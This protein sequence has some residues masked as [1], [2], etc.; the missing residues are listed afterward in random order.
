[1]Y[2]ILTYKKAPLKTWKLKKKNIYIKLF[3][4]IF[5]AMLHEDTEFIALITWGIQTNTYNRQLHNMLNKI[6]A[7]AI[8]PYYVSLGQHV[9]F[10]PIL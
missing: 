1:M 6:S 4:Q 5:F 2:K 10:G 8:I 3:L 9:W 7:N